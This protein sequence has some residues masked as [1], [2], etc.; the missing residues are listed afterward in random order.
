MAQN[1]SVLRLQLSIPFRIPA[2]LSEE[3][4]KILTEV[5]SIP[6][7]I[8]EAIIEEWAED[9]GIDVAVKEM[10]EIE[11]TGHADVLF[12][13]KKTLFVSLEDGKRISVVLKFGFRRRATTFE[14]EKVEVNY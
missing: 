5:L 13:S 14:V 6:F 1:L 12:F 8:P 3:I 7:R 10:P 9:Y 11:E 4:T 2:K